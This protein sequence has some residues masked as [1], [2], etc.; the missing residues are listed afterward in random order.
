MLES[1]NDELS[2][3]LKKR[4]RERGGLIGC[5][6]GNNKHFFTTTK[7]SQPFSLDRIFSAMH[8]KKQ[9]LHTCI[10]WMINT[11]TKDGSND[12]KARYS[13]LSSQF[14]ARWMFQLLIHLTRP[15]LSASTEPVEMHVTSTL[16]TPLPSSLIF[17]IFALVFMLCES[18]IKKNSSQA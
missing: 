13:L 18:R 10:Q 17:I 4:E 11:H 3:S 7:N 15:S 8:V 14:I 12:S 16:S 5:L 6:G 9:S 2:L 1:R